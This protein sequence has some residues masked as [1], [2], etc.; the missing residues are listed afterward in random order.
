PVTDLLAVPG[1][2]VLVG[3]PRG[4]DLL[5]GGGSNPSLKPLW[6]EPTGLQDWVQSMTRWG[7]GMVDAGAGKKVIARDAARGRGSALGDTASPTNTLLCDP[8]GRLL[9]GT[10]T[11]L[12]RVNRHDGSLAPLCQH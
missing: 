2:G 3:S 5:S 12:F 11:G 9:L 4:V 8:A 7:D 1:G 10:A 6:A